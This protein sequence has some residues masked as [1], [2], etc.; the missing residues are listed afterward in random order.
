MLTLRLARRLGPGGNSAVVIA[1]LVLSGGVMRVF[2]GH[3]EVY[4]AHLVAVV[5]YLW[6]A[7][8]YIEGRVRW[9]APCLALGVAIWVHASAVLLLPGL[10]LLPFTASPGLRVREWVKRA[11]QGGLLAAVPCLVFFGAIALTG[12]S[13]DLLLAWKKALEVLG[14]NPDPGAIRWWVRGWGGAP[15]IGTDV[16][17]LSRGQLKFLI[18]SLFVLFPFALPCLLVLVV[19]SPRRLVA[20]PQARFLAAT[21]LPTVLYAFLLRPFWGPFD[22]DLFAIT[23]IC[24]AVLAAHWLAVEFE[25]RSF[26]KLAVWL[27]AFNLLF[28]GLPFLLAGRLE[29]R[30]AGPFAPGYFDLDLRLPDRP[31]AEKLAPWL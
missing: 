13:K 27:I 30:E 1:M 20:T 17:F 26:R 23:G 14:Q 31:P 3:I 11:V 18:N 28:V 10:A 22:W 19:R 12:H 16:V 8:S 2:A 7:L 6:L 29:L 9:V 4:A 15:S 5:A 24:L 25:P 21:S